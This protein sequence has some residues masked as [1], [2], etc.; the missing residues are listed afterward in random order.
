MTDYVYLIVGSMITMIC[1]YF[2]AAPFFKREVAVSQ[3]STDQ[4]QE[5]SIELI[6][7]AVNELEMDFLMKKITQA[8][9][10]QMKQRYQIMAAEYLRLEEQQ[11][12]KEVDEALYF[13][14]DIFLELQEIRKKKGRHAG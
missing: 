5:M 12:R 7:A 1:F 9:F 10:L 3:V 4:E 11:I 14:E 8:D 2:M 13:D 6:Y